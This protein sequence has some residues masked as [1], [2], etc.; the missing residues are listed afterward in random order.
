MWLHC[1]TKVS[2]IAM[3]LIVHNQKHGSDSQVLHEQFG[4]LE[5]NIT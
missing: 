1:H 4:G 2:L 5:Q 3:K